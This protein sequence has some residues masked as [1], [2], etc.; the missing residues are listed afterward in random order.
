MKSRSNLFASSLFLLTMFG[1]SLA[2]ATSAYAQAND[3]LLKAGNRVKVLRAGAPVEKGT[4]TAVVNDSVF[5]RTMW[6]AKPEL[7]AVSMADIQRVWVQPRSS[8]AGRAFRFA[9]LG[10]LIGGTAAYAIAKPGYHRPV[11][12]RESNSTCG[13][14]FGC[15]YYDYTVCDAHCGE[16]T[17]GASA[18]GGALFGML[19]GVITGVAWEGRWTRIQFR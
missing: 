15:I 13:G 4:I 18:Q 3:S 11:T 6:S 5:Y 1:Y 8:R 2:T 7:V 10:G 19:A 12:H 9:L 14:L 17:P 16:T